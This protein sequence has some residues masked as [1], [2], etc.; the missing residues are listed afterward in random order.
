MASKPFYSSRF[1]SLRAFL[2]LSFLGPQGLR[3]PSVYS[4]PLVWCVGAPWFVER[5]F[6]A[7]SL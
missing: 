3:A 4:S 1:V 7:S 6:A 5:Q 2:W